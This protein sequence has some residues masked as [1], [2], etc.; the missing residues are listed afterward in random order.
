[1]D[2]EGVS[3]A[4]STCR[5]SCPRKVFD[6]ILEAKHRKCSASIF[7]R[8]VEH[9]NGARKDTR[10]NL[11]CWHFVLTRRKDGHTQQK[12]L[13]HHQPPISPDI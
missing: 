1:M 4:I 3:P 7:R 9:Y 11:P 5:V 12:Q 8:L 6:L 13:Q 10:G 2:F